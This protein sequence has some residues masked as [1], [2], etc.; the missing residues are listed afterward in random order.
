MHRRYFA[1]TAVVIGLGVLSLG[2][3]TASAQEEMIGFWE[4]DYTYGGYAGQTTDPT[5]VG[6]TRQIEFQ[7]DWTVQSFRD[8]VPYEAGTWTYDGGVTITGLSDFP[9]QDGAPDI[10]LVDLVRNLSLVEPCCDSYE[11]HFHDRAEIVETVGAAF[12]AVKALYR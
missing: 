9:V 12:G 11:F 10:V 1:V 4:W 7:A 5:S 3:T 6:H 8:E 2:A